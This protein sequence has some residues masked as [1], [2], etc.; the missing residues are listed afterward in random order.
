LLREMGDKMLYSLL[1]VLVLSGSTVDGNRKGHGKKCK[2][3]KGYN[4]DFAKCKG[5]K[6]KVVGESPNE[7]LQTIN[8]TV[9]ENGEKLDQLLQGKGGVNTKPGMVVFGYSYKPPQPEPTDAFIPYHVVTNED[10]FFCMF[11]NVSNYWRLDNDTTGDE[12]SFYI[13][14]KSPQKIKGFRLKNSHNCNYRDMGTQDF[15][16]STTNSWVGAD[17]KDP[18]N[19]P[20]YSSWNWTNHLVATLPDP[21]PPVPVMDFELE[22]PIEE[23]QFLRFRVD[24]YWGVGGALQY[25]APY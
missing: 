21:V 2:R 14:F 7:I 11:G 18:K 23:T 12:A 13:V 6:W 5:G 3:P 20:P 8:N 10:D 16:F 22:T 1:L 19:A 17:P 24:S 4:G 9:A 15:T 25:F